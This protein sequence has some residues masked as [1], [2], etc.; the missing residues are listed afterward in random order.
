MDRRKRE[1]FD[2][3]VAEN[4]LPLPFSPYITS[5]ESILMNNYFVSTIFALLVYLPSMIV[6]LILFV[7]QLPLT[8]I[9]NLVLKLLGKFDSHPALIKHMGNTENEQTL[10]RLFN[11]KA[12][13]PT[14]KEKELITVTQFNLFTYMG[15]FYNRYPLFTSIL[16]KEKSD[17]ICIQEAITSKYLPIGTLNTMKK[18]NGCNCNYDGFMTSLFECAPIL[19]PLLFKN[20]YL[21]RMINECQILLNSL[22]TISTFG[23]Y[24]WEIALRLNGIYMIFSF[25]FWMF[26]GV[27]FQFGNLI[28]FK[29]GQCLFNDL[30]VL[31]PGIYCASCIVYTSSN[32]VLFVF[33]FGVVA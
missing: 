1:N 17:I 26:T 10:K 14:S 20:S 12:R 19:H 8:V 21:R 24:Y 3:D 29:H 6:L 5:F 16:N 13:G 2:N 25:I 11:K 30:L 23:K 27:V 15:R 33:F 9:L 18:M 31:T 32:V 4:A 22:F 28:A 7:I